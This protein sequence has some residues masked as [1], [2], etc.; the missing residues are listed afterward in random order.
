MS[1]AVAIAH[2]AGSISVAQSKIFTHPTRL[3]DCWVPAI[4]EI[5]LPGYQL[6]RPKIEIVVEESRTGLLGRSRNINSLKN[7]KLALKSVRKKF[8]SAIQLNDRYLFDSRYEIDS[9]I[10]HLLD[11]VVPAVLLARQTFPSLVVIMR[12]KATTMAKT[13][14]DLLRIPIICTDADVIGRSV[15]VNQAGQEWFSGAGLYS[16]VFDM[17]S[18]DGYKKGTPE[19]IFIS[20]RR[21]RTLL[22]EAEV[23]G[24]LRQRGFEKVYF[25]D[26]PICE[27]WSLARNAK[28]IVGIHGAALNSNVFNRNAVKV[29]ELFHP[30]YVLNFYRHL[31]NAVGGTWRG[32]TGKLPPDIIR[33]LDYKNE[34]VFYQNQPMRIHITSLRMALDDLGI[35]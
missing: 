27:Q 32:V 21:T 5:N 15:V 35:G 18:F 11:N 12:S 14:F 22:N 1:D 16:S 4:Q 3:A 13:V 19:R 17:I 10:S 8:L 28:A 20:R 2:S 33:R 26:I 23:E 31:T 6:T 29:V 34:E 9:N 25:E 24:A 7:Y 30:G